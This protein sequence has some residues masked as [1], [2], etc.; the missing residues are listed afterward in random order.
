[1]KPVLLIALVL[2]LC[3]TVA[4]AQEASG[5]PRALATLAVGQ[6]LDL[7]STIAAL[8]R[9]TVETNPLM[10]KRPSSAKLIA[11]KLPMLGVGWL[12]VKLAP[13]HPKLAKGTAYVIGGVGLGLAIHN[14]RQGRQ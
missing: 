2:I 11:A 14:V 6:S 10:G 8:N 5:L 1:V 4:R 12:L 9:G 3:P 13:S 7:V